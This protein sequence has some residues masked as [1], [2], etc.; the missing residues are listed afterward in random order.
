MS[1][2]ASGAG[3]SLLTGVCS[4]ALV[5]CSLLGILANLKTLAH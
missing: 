5:V 3:V 4:L 2:A 1:A